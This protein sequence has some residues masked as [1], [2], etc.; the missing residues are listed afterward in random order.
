[1]RILLAHG[2]DPNIRDANGQTALHLVPKHARSAAAIKL[3]IEA[4][5]ERHLKDDAGNTPLDYAIQANSTKTISDLL[6]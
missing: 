4:G 3:L 5:A 6:S 1:M 2:A